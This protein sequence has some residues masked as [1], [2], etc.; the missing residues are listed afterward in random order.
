MSNDLISLGLVLA[1]GLGLGLSF[2]GGR[3]RAVAAVV[4]LVQLALAGALL[5]WISGVSLVLCAWMLLGLGFT[6]LVNAWRS[7]ALSMATSLGVIGLAL[8]VLAGAARLAA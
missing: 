6:L 8:L 5:G 7:L 1:S 3:A 2:R 4:T